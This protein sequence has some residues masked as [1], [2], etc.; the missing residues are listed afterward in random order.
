MG[1]LAQLPFEDQFVAID[2]CFQAGEIKPERGSQPPARLNQRM[3]LP[4]LS[5]EIP[6]TIASLGPSPPRYGPHFSTRKKRNR[7]CS[8]ADS[9]RQIAGSAIGDSSLKRGKGGTIQQEGLVLQ[10]GWDGIFSN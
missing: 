2:I 3:G 9:S 4:C 8:L 7:R 1:I 5:E 10:R 6:R